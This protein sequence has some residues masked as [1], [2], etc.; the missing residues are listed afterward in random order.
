MRVIIAGSR[1]M[2]RQAEVDAAIA[3]SGFDISAVVCGMAPGV[4]TLGGRWA[5]RNG[6]PVVQMPANWDLYGKAAG[7]I[8]NAEMLKVADAVIV[9][10]DGKSRGS[11]H[12]LMI[13]KASGKPWFERVVEIPEVR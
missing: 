5:I 6:I 1:S 11:A 4:D 2:W 12:M 10:W 7:P 8:R 9:V 3:E 13:A